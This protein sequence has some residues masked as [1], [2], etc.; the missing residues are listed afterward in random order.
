MFFVSRNTSGDIVAIARE[1]NEQ[2]SEAITTDNPELLTFLKQ[3]GEDADILSLLQ[4]SDTPLIRVL[5]DL[6]QLLI[7][8]NM[9]QF[10][11]L[12]TAAQQKLLERKE[13]RT[14]LSDLSTDSTLIANSEDDPLI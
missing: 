14:R 10:T 9:I 7:K 8:K 2:F 1:Q 5:E 13:I 11:E 12:P 6:I 4:S 3:H